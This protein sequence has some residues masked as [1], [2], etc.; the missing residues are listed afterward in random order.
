MTGCEVAIL[1]VKLA[2]RTATP[3]VSG[4]RYA[5]VGMVAGLGAENEE[6]LCKHAEHQCTEQPKPR[7]DSAWTR[8]IITDS[9]GLRST[10]K[11]WR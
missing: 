4:V 10:T 7:L 1:A 9:Q 11:W 5:L 2:P 8:A 6:T 3:E